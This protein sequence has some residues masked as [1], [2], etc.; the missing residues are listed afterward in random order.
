MP[1]SNSATKTYCSAQ[2]TLDGGALA[3]VQAHREQLTVL[4]RGLAAELDE[5]DRSLSDLAWPPRARLAGV[6]EAGGTADRALLVAR[7]VQLNT[8]LRG[9]ARQLSDFDRSNERPAARVGT[10]P[11][12]GYPSLD[13]GMCAFCRPFA[14]R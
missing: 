13:S 6:I 10:C 12:C 2:P 4:L 11:H 7:R 5:L 8:R 3:G 14:A 9:L 1:G